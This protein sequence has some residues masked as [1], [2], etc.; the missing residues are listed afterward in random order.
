MEDDLESIPGWTLTA[1][2]DSFT[3]DD[4]T[5]VDDTASPIAYTFVAGT[6]PWTVESSS[7]SYDIVSD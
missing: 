4:Y 3:D 7:V 5:V 2:T 6:D 1:S